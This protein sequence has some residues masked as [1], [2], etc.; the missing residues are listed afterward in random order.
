MTFSQRY[1]QISL[2]RN[3][4]IG[5]VLVD[6]CSSGRKA[7]ETVVLAENHCFTIEQGGQNITVVPGSVFGLF[8]STH[9]LI[10]LFVIFSFTC[11]T[12]L[13]T[14]KFR[15]LNKRSPMQIHFEISQYFSYF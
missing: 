14:P 4:H 3:L 13:I 12:N 10:H 6:S 1:P 8:L 5:T 11:S 9:L 15:S 7:V 2:L